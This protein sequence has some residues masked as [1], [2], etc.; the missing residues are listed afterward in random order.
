[1]WLYRKTHLGAVIGRWVVPGSLASGVISL[2][3]G[4][5]FLDFRPLL[6]R[7]FE[8]GVKQNVN[9]SRLN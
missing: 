3:T 8:S 7:I 6:E 5:R 1:M 9:R 2:V 4:F